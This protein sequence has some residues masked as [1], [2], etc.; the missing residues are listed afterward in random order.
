MSSVYNHDIVGYYNRINRFL[1]ELAKSN[2]SNVSL[3]SD[4]D[5]S[6]LMKS[7]EALDSYQAWVCGQPLLD[8]PETAP[9]SYDLKD[10]PE[11]P[12]VENDDI[13]NL[14][15]LFVIIREEL[16]NSQSARMASGLIDFDSNR[17]T[18]IITKARNFVE[19]YINVVGVLD[20]PES[21]PLYPNTGSGLTGI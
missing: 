13:S 12:I 6:R 2:S 5:K 15:N 11:I 18:T 10:P 21:S 7:L 17:M 4:A 19:S 1:V 3:F 14:L 8:L 20:L 16:I 9:N